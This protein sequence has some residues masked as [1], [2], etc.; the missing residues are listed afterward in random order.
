MSSSRTIGVLALQGSFA[1]HLTMLERLGCEGRAV[2][3]PE[4][5]DGLDGLIIPG[6]ESTTIGKLAVRY[7]L[8]DPIRRRAG[9]GLP[10]WGTCAGLIFLARD[11]GDMEQPGLNLM[12]IAVSRNAFGSQIQSFESDLAVPVLGPPDFH[13]VFIRAPLI[14]STGPGVEILARLADGGIVAA[15]QDNLLVTAFHP[16]LTEDSRFHRHFV[17]KIG[18]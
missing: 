10:I 14:V 13:G 12:D 9:E 16:E 15:S 18:A 3:L 8:V 2:R 4:E 5:L 6:G 1:E 17:D 7:G 11:L